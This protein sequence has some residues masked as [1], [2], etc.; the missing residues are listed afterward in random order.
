[1]TVR[2]LVAD[3]NE[4][5]R[6][7]LA[8][9][10]HANGYEVLHASDGEEALAITRQY[11]P[12]LILL[13]IMMPKIDGIEVCKRVKADAVLQFT[14]VILVTAK[15][16]TGDVVEGLDAGADEYLTKPVDQR[17]LIA[18]VRALL[19][20]KDRYESGL[21]QSKSK[22]AAGIDLFI[23]YSRQDGETI[24]PLAASLKQR[25]WSVWFDQHLQAG[26]S[27]DRVIE[28]ALTDA[29]AV[30]VA[31]SKNSVNSDWVR[32]EAAFAQES[33]KLL[34]IRL[35][36]APLPLRFTHVHTLSF[37]NWD[38]SSSHEA[39]QALDAH[40]REAIGNPQGG[41]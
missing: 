27:F 25:G 36:G 16:D 34:P 10:L 19:R 12:N 22:K 31:W 7:I 15:S 32:A 39:L 18:R 20:L 13:D 4:I 2:I 37:H 11:R 6:D 41:T 40:L 33:G 14:P 38:G 1:V 8:T 23:S 21:G 5:N 24:K 35:D 26:A 30:I 9:R 17:A 28:Q 3:D 29:R